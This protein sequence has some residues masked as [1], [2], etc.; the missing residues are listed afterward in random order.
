MIR[1]RLDDLGWYQFEWLIQAL[2]KSECGLAVET[3]SASGGDYGKDAFCAHELTFPSKSAL[4]SGPFVFQVKFVENANASGAKPEA[5][6]Q[7]AIKKEIDRIQSRIGQGDW[8]K[9]AYYSLITNVPLSPSIRNKLTSKLQAALPET[10]IILWGTNDV[11]DILDANENIRRSFPQLLS[12]RDLDELIRGALNAESRERSLSAIENAR[13][14]V[15]VFVPTRA[16]EHCWEIL[17]EHH[18][19]VLEGPPEVGKTA[20]A[21]MIAINQI[22]QGWEGISCDKPEDF[23][24]RHDY[25]RHQIFIADDAFGRTEYS[26]TSGQ[27]WEKNLARILNR[28]DQQHWLIWTSRKNILEKAKQVWDLQEPATRFPSPGDVLVDASNLTRY[29]KALI[30]YRHAKSAHFEQQTKE[31]LKQHVEEI[32]DDPSFTPERIRRFIKDTI[33]VLANRFQKGELSDQ[34]VKTEIRRAIQTPTVQMRKSFKALPLSHK[35]YLVSLLG[36]DRNDIDV[37]DSH[38]IYQQ[39]VAALETSENIEQIIEELSESFIRIVDRG[40]R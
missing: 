28:L 6:I 36:T 12:L 35:I 7:N 9:P 4:T 8:E 29:E 31:I 38:Q 30:L 26:V 11:C 16:Y 27:E 33:P 13:I 15:N 37:K 21:W 25:D 20:I 2:L 10:K 5:A 22:S 24:G 17:R 1:Y 39:R 3:W 34:Q 23:F 14:L 32:V 19:A 40:I 18:F